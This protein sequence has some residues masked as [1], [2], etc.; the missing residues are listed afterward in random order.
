MR[1]NRNPNPRL[2]K[3]L[4]VTQKGLKLSKKIIH[5]SK[6]KSDK[7]PT[8]NMTNNRIPLPPHFAYAV[9]GRKKRYTNRSG[10]SAHQRVFGKSLRL[11]GSLMSDHPID[12][13]AVATDDTTEFQRTAEIRDAALKAY[14]KNKSQEAIKKAYKARPRAAVKYEFK[15]GDIV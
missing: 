4:Y 13:M 12:R 10:F 5:D 11:P 15:A 8:Q 7:I 2:S 6:G 9:F 3:R 1:Y 14:I